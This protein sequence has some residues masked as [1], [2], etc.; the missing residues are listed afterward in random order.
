MESNLF[1][2]EKKHQLKKV[3]NTLITRQNHWNEYNNAFENI[4]EIIIPGE[5][6]HIVHARHL[7]TILIRLTKLKIDR[8]N[9]ILE[10]K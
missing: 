2:V 4:D 7:Y 5:S 9:F 1:K 8:D 3:N 6:E 10:L